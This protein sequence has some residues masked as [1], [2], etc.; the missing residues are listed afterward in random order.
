MLSLKPRPFVQS[1]FDMQAPRYPHVL[2]FFFGDVAFSDYFCCTIFAFSLYGEYV[3]RYF[4]PNGVFLPCD[5][6]L[7]FLHQLAYVVV[8]V[9]VVI[10]YAVCVG[11]YLSIH[12]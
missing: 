9:V 6:G 7:D 4:L 1:S 10:P 3:G 12:C 5:H 11:T 8:V 2:I